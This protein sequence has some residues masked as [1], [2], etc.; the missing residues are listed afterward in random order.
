M[1]AFF[2]F[3]VKEF[4]HITRDARTLLVLFGIPFAQLL[5]FGYAIRT[6]INDIDLGVLDYSKDYVTQEITNK[7][8]SSGY[9]R[10]Q[11]YL[12]NEQEVEKAFQAG[13]VKQVIVYEPGFAHKLLKEGT[14]NIQILNDASNPNVATMINSYAQGVISDYRLGLIQKN[15]INPLLIVNEV[16]MLFNPEIKSVYMFVPGLIA[17]L[18]MLIS[19]LM[20]SVALTKEKEFGNMEILLASP[21]RSRIIIIGKVIPYIALAFIDGIIVLFLAY[22]VFGVPLRGSL[23]LVLAE[24]ILYIITSLAVGIFISTIAK[25]QQVAM[26]V[27]LV[28]LLLPTMLLS[29]FIY[30]IENMPYILQLVTKIIPATWFLIIIK[31]IMLKG[32]GIEYLWKETLILFG[33]MLFFLLVSIKKFKIRLE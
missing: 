13:K 20:T 28:G 30:P 24:M 19:A 9:F 3:I 32:V 27:S 31:G 4:Y 16:Q 25:T 26:M 33:M 7:L 10:L 29:G 2:Q 18:L 8:I 21:L 14:A 1:R 6:E 11:A 15:N 22:T 23:F 17:M 12:Q 5:I